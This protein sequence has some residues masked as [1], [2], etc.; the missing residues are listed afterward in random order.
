MTEFAEGRR[1]N[2]RL[3]LGILMVP[4]AMFGLGF[5][6][7]PFYDQVCEY[8]GVTPKVRAEA[9]ADAPYRVDEAREIALGFITS[10]NGSMPLEFRVEVPKLAIHPGQ[11]Y[12]V[13]FYAKN[14]SGKKLIGQ[15]IPSV[16]PV[17]AAGHLKKTQCFCFAEQEFEP[18]VE[19]E[20][21]VRFVVDPEVSADVKDMTLSYTFFDITDKKIQ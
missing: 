9:T 21:P 11:Y 17:W 8:F 14:V 15:A 2:V 19:K 4:V 6:V 12:T 10:V 1:S 3:A 20:M 13:K 5:A 16:A 18:N 7:A